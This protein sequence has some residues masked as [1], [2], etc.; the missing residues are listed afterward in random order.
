MKHDRIVSLL[1]FFQVYSKSMKEFDTYIKSFA[2]IDKYYTNI[3][4]NLNT[5]ICNKMNYSYGKYL[6]WIFNFFIR[7]L[8]S[9]TF[10][11][12]VLYFHKFYY[13]YKVLPLL[14]IFI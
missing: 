2:I 11:I 6:T 5:F 12:D 14:V 9:L 4:Y 3:M 8:V 10:S 13:F 1:S 7:I